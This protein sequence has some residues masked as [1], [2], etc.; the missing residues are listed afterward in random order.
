MRWFAFFEALLMVVSRGIDIW[1]RSQ[2][3]KA[4][5]ELQSDVEDI[6]RD[7]VDY[8][9]REYGGLPDVSDGAAGAGAV[10]GD[11]AQA[12]EDRKAE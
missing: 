12:V 1:Q 6:T 7:P 10:S 8:A 11:K 9:Q 4:E 5:R 3:R 2:K